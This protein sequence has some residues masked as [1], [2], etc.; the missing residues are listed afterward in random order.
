MSKFYKYLFPALF[1]MLL[2][3][4]GCNTYATVSYQILHIEGI[5]WATNISTTYVS[6]G[7]GTQSGESGRVSLPVSDGDLLYLFNEDEFELYYRYKLED[8]ALLTVSFDTVKAKS[9]HVNGS[10]A[11]LQITDNPSTW[12]KFREL[13]ASEVNQ[14]STLYISDQL[15]S[16]ILDVL[17]THES[18]LTG[19]G[20]VLENKPEEGAIKELLS[21]CRP[22]WLGLQGGV[23]LNEDIG[24][25]F[26][27]DLE[28]LWISEDVHVVSNMI[29]CCSNIKSLIITDW[30]PLGG[31]LVQLSGLENFHSLTLG[32]CYISDLSNFEFPASLNRLHLIGCD[33]LT[34]ISALEQ[35]PSLNSLNLTG[36]D[37]L[38]SLD[39][40]GKLG[41]LKWLSFPENTTQEEFQ[42][43]LTSQTS[44]EVVELI[45]CPFVSNISNLR[46]QSNLKALN[47][48]SEEYKFDQFTDL[49][50][51]E[52][53][54]LD[55]SVFEDSPEL[56]SQLQTKLP[57]TEIV[58][59]SGLCLGSGW[60]MLL[61][62]LLLL[63]RFLFR[64]VS[65]L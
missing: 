11:F 33:T 45:N 3:L 18:S 13:S 41:D 1:C 48:L 16:E 58:P 23:D 44:L 38:G 15:N 20:L 21:I 56:I 28:L 62:P 8:G 19:T 55:Y 60:L 57:D 25:K 63:T 53:I 52:L 12:D 7:S 4:Q 64:R 59:G 32:D 35:L 39:V 10:L 29:Q 36:S 22:G 17:K 51:L 54:M 61:F 26:L 46:D 49:G 42:I 24:A 47:Y 9:A 34:D 37:D 2:D 40:I 50:Q 5:S 14:L 43:I 31:E 6:F 65:K 30:E 27:S